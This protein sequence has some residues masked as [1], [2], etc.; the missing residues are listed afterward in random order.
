MNKLIYIISIIGFVTFFSCNKRDQDNPTVSMSKPLTASSYAHLDVI[1][2][3]GVASDETRLKRVKVELLN[4]NFNGVGIS[5]EIKVS[6][7]SEN[8]TFQLYLD[9]IHLVSGTMYVKVTVTDRADNTAS[10]WKQITYSEVPL[11]LKDIYV[12]SSGQSAFYDLYKVSG[13]ATQFSKTLSG[14]F[15]DL[16][17]NSYEQQIILSGGSVGNLTALEPD[18]YSEVWEKTPNST[19]QPYY[20]NLQLHGN[21]QTVLVSSE[22]PSVRSYNKTGGQGNSVILS[23]T[24]IPNEILQ[25]GTHTFV[26]SVYPGGRDLTLFYSNTGALFH[27]KIWQNDIAKMIPKDDEEIYVFS[28]GAGVCFMDIYNIDQNATYS[29][30]NLPI[31]TVNDVCSISGNELFIAHSSGI[32]KYTY[33]NNSLV[34]IVSG[35]N[36]GVIKYDPVGNRILAAA[37]NEVSSYDVFGA[38][39]QTYNHSSP[40]LDFGLFYNK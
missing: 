10:T 15:Q 3:E 22:E 2:V 20:T 12:V 32:L 5:E 24:E 25:M 37:G 30:I 17:C 29:L 7:T 16:L 19:L 4:V 23:G 9:D 6:G 35:L 33:S 28:N 38:F 36:A 1:S 31:G 11:A 39:I 34:T 14:S 40:I 18:F 13:S 8:F 27:T 21:G 26:E